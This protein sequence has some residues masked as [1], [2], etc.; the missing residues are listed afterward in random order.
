MSFIA[1]YIK[2]KG[3]KKLKQL[4]EEKNK[5]LIIGKIVKLK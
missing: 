1:I 3:E 4:K 5:F 2:Q